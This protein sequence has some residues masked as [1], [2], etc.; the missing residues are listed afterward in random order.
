[1]IKKIGIIGDSIAHGFYD[2]FL[3]AQ[4]LILKTS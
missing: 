3:Q 4:N 2:A 1:M